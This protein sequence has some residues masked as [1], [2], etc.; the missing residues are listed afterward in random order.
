[1]SDTYTKLFASIT[2]STIWQAPASARLTWITMLAMAHKDGSVYAS[3][4]GLAHLANVPLADV[5]AALEYFKAPDKYSRTKDYE[6]RRI[7]EI[8]GGW[9]LLNHAKFREIRSAAER[10]D[11]MRKHMRDKRARGK[12]DGAAARASLRD[13]LAEPLAPVSEVAPPAPAPAPSPEKKDQRK[14]HARATRSPLVCMPIDFQ[15]SDRVRLWAEAKGN[16]RLEEHL[17]A[18]RDT[19]SARA[20]EY[21][22]WDSAFMKAIREDWAKLRTENG[23]AN[24]TRN[25]ESLCDRAARKNRQLDALEAGSAVCAAPGS[26][27]SHLGTHDRDVRSQLV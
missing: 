5:E 10:A 18:F 9:R 15:I 19:A 21:A 25:R 23:N 12:E 26:I 16:A 14:K 2:A 13:K 7:E 27:A 8:D 17:E 11:Y 4:P 6:G 1:M 22:D 24:S 20:Y 3:V